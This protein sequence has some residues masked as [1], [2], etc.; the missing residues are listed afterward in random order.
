MPDGQEKQTTFNNL[1]SLNIDSNPTKQQV[2]KQ[3][4]TRPHP[5]KRQPKQE[6]HVYLGQEEA[7]EFLQHKTILDCLHRQCK[8]GCFA[9]DPYDY[10]TAHT[11][12]TGMVELRKAIMKVK[13]R[14]QYL[15][16]YMIS[17]EV[18]KDESHVKRK[19]CYRAPVEGRE[20]C[21]K[22][23]AHA[24]GF[25][26]ASGN[27]SITFK[28][29]LAAFNHGDCNVDFSRNRKVKTNTRNMD[30]RIVAWIER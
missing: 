26:D 2:H 28:R 16:D 7:P 10:I 3:P 9:H 20:I 23:F 29:T 17:N 1:Q 25:V 8:H 14:S 22:C 27:Q 18:V 15:L 21:A 30:A 11:L 6:A 12:V 4:A 13:H 5:S 24:A 19:V